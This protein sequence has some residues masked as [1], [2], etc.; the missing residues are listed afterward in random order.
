MINGQ[1]IKIWNKLPEEIIEEWIRRWNVRKIL[2]DKEFYDRFYPNFYNHQY[3]PLLNDMILF[4][5]NAAFSVL[6][7]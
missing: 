2:S 1:N 4:K 5:N 7:R 6:L 3:E